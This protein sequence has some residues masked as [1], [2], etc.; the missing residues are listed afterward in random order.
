MNDSLIPVHLGRVQ[1]VVPSE[2]QCCFKWD[3]TM[4]WPVFLYLRLFNRF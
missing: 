4:F 2:E 3:G 1:K